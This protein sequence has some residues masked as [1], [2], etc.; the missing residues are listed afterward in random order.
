MKRRRKTRRL[1]K[2]IAVLVAVDVLLLA[3]IITLF[4]LHKGP[5]E[6]QRDSLAQL[7]GPEARNMDEAELDDARLRL[8]SDAIRMV[9]YNPMPEYQDG[10]INIYLSNAE[11]NTC[12]VSAEIKLLTDGSVIADTGLIDPGYRL[13]TL[14]IAADL[15]LGEYPC[16]MVLQA[17][18]Q[19][20]THL[21]QA[22]RNLTL[23]VK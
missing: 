14:E 8:L 3:G 5:E 19:G 9:T 11:E 23:L 15:P 18:S 1:V 16:L 4:A 13:E 12:S 2:I 6:L 20:G 21:G 17:Y 22:G 7:I 10:S